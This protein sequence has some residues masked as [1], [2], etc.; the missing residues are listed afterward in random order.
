VLR[1]GLS[2]RSVKYFRRG[3]GYNNWYEDADLESDVEIRHSEPRSR[4]NFA[5]MKIVPMEDA[6][7]ERSGAGWIK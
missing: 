4:R 1:G 2:S 5:S 7:L 3:F 6:T